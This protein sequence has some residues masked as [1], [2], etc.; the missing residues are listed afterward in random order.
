MKI[1][2]VTYG[3]GHADIVARIIPYLKQFNNVSCH[4]L[5]LTT[6]V[7][8]LDRHHIKYKKCSDYLT[9]TGYHSALEIGDKLSRPIW[10]SST[11]I[12]YSDSC[13]YMGISM[14][15]LMNELGEHEAIKQYDKLGRKAFLPWS[16]LERVIK[17]E[18]PDIVVTTCN[19]RMEKAAIIAANKNDIPSILI[20]D[21]FGYS[22]CGFT[23]LEHCKISSKVEHLPKNIFVLND[24]VKNRLLKAKSLLTDV[25]VTG[26][27]VFSELS[28]DLEKTQLQEKY[29]LL[30]QKNKYVVTYA[31]PGKIDVFKSQLSELKQLVAIRRD[32]HFIIKLHPSISIDCEV[33]DELDSFPNNSSVTHKDDVLQSLKISDVIIVYRSTVG[34]QAIFSGKKLLVWG[35]WEDTKLLPYEQS[36][37]ARYAKNIE[38][39]ST[40]LEKSLKSVDDDFTD[41]SEVFFNTPNAL[42]NIYKA[43]KMIFNKYDTGNC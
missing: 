8:I 29:K 31:A 43:M 23:S 9:T 15:D 13:A 34:L 12:E 33:Q 6:A 5:A 41:E 10:H 38:Q 40:E 16:F 18:S 11:G 27:P 1:L 20:D 32:I 35:N 14:L 19:V 17:I 21:L 26:Q 4:V 2:F 24:F 36:Y 30:K 28:R 39:L 25:Y 42:Q 22:L 37:N 7:N 3:G